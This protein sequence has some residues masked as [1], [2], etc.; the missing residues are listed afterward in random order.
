M[1]KFVNTAAVMGLLSL[2]YLTG[3]RH[4]DAKKTGKTANHAGSLIPFVEY[5]SKNEKLWGYLD[6]DTGE[7][8]IKAQYVFASPFTGN[9]AVVRN[10]QLDEESIINKDGEVIPV[11]RFDEVYFITSENGRGA[12]AILG[13]QYTRNKLHI[14]WLSGFSI[15]SYRQDY[16]KYRM[17]N[18]VTGKTIVPKRKNSLIYTVE[19]V[20]EYFLV[21]GDLYQF[22]DTGDI[23]YIAK[24]D[25][26]LTVNIL[27]DYFERRGIIAHLSI[28]GYDIKIDYRP[29]IEKIYADPDLCGALTDLAS[30]FDMPFE[31]A[32]PFYRDPKIYLNAPLE[33]SK[34]IYLVYFKN[35]ETKE[36]AVGL[37]NATEAKWIIDPFFKIL[38]TATDT[39]KT[40]YTVD[41]LQTNNP[42]VYRVLLTNDEIGWDRHILIS[43]GIYS[44][45]KQNFADNLYLFEDFPPG[46]LVLTLMGG[47]RILRFPDYG[48]YYRDYSRIKE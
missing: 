29:Y 16:S 4:I 7:I 21:G 9:Y 48:V 42:R 40:Y 41:I 14:A 1:V 3:C 38:F 43:G 17:V 23:K 39:Q 13:N 19:T 12:A 37:Y 11:G 8:V 44:T 2:F 34:R 30:E 26:D 46:K 24:N 25:P 22:M 45:E 35:N 47:R 10:N 6:E 5:D 28:I 32:V 36:R 31:R 33:I 20:G 27:E 15:G 18:L